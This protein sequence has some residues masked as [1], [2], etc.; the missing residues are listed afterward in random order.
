MDLDAYVSEQF[1]AADAGGAVLV[2]QAGTLLLDRGYGDADRA[3]QRPNTPQT[4]FQ[5]ASISKQFAAAAIL[6]LQERGAL[7]VHDRIPT[8]VPHCPA[9]WE[10]ITVHH[11]LTHT[12]GIGHWD[13]YA[14]ELS[15]YAPNTRDHLIRI[16]QRPPLL[17][18][19][20]S[21][22]HYSSP[23][24]VLL[25]HIVEQSTGDAYAAFLAANIFRPV[26]MDSTGAGSGAPYPERRAVGYTA[27]KP[28][29][30]F[31]LD[32]VG[33][34]AG[35][36]WSTTAD[37]ARWDAALA[38]PGLL[39]E[40][41]LTAMFAPHAVTT[42][43]FPEIPIIHYGYGWLIATLA[44]HKVAYHTGGNAGY[45]S[46][47]VWVPDDDI[48]IVILANEDVT[49]DTRGMGMRIASELVLR[50]GGPMRDTSAPVPK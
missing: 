26:G 11:L 3:R 42:R 24:F 17:F 12:S 4:T 45:V 48:L 19:P 23:A 49:L 40:R 29:P 30:S 2:R 31:D 7:S 21:D 16:F 47:N 38:A 15:L 27:G 28:A 18:P 5:I 44:G 33:I 8:W 25:A 13:A 1:Q 35:D 20:G 50:G 22:W 14:P 46:I 37:M 6:L 41:S 10:P 34:G 36:I 39:G 43:S 9:A 32:D